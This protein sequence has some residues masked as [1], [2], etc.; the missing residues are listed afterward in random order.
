MIDCHSWQLTPKI[1]VKIQNIEVEP[2]L[3]APKW[4][5]AGQFF[6]NAAQEWCLL[7]LNNSRE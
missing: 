4:A 1:G 5:I 3:P 2:G 6:R 7:K